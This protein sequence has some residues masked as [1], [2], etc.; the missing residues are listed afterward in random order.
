MSAELKEKIAEAALELSDVIFKG[1]DIGEFNEERHLNAE[2][3]LKK[4]LDPSQVRDHMAYAANLAKVRLFYNY[5]DYRNAWRQE[6]IN[7]A[8]KAGV[9]L[10]IE[11]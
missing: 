11:K 10:N 4:Y 6:A 9:R 3:E 8:Q 7:D 1:I 5:K 2:E